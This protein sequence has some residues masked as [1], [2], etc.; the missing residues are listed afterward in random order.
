MN[1]YK[2]DEEGIKRLKFATKKGKE[3][4][5]GEGGD[6]SKIS[7]LNENESNIILSISGGYNKQLSLL[8]KQKIE[9]AKL[10]EEIILPPEE[11]ELETLVISKNSKRRR[12]KKSNT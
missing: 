6:D 12:I 9:N 1:I 7:Y 4:E 11:I 8:F 5:V 3:L 10:D 2:T